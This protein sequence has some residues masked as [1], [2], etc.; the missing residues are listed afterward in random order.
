MSNLPICIREED[1][2]K[3]GEIATKYGL[4]S[5]E[6]MDLFD[7]LIKFKSSENFTK[8]RRDWYFFLFMGLYGAVALGLTYWSYLKEKEEGER[9]ERAIRLAQW[10]PENGHSK[11]GNKL[12]KKAKNSMSKRSKKSKS[13]RSK[14]SSKSKR[15]KMS[16]KSSK[17]KK[18]SSKKKSKKEKLSVKDSFEALFD[19]SFS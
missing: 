7:A 5:D 11:N 2:E 19:S 18:R 8:S 14:K 13:T 9:L 1:F 3:F 17:K 10:M 15:S 4:H 16:K 6:I 12:R